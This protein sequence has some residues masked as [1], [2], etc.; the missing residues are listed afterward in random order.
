MRQYLLP[1]QI[2]QPLYHFFIC[3]FPCFPT[4]S[5]P[6]GFLPLPIVF[7]QSFLH[8]AVLPELNKS[9]YRYNRHD[10][11]VY[12]LDTRLLGYS[13]HRCLAHYSLDTSPLPGCPDQYLPSLS[14]MRAGARL[15]KSVSVGSWCDVCC[16]HFNLNVFHRLG[17]LERGIGRDTQGG[18]KTR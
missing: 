4:F 8:I 17:K 15:I 1:T 12:I 5:L 18:L 2:S 11:T 13:Y 3:T 7:S 16:Y 10:A 6:I 14:T 9:N